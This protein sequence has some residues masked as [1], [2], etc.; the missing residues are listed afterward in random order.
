MEKNVR[1]LGPL[2]I[3]LD[4]L[5]DWCSPD[6]P[7][8]GGFAHLPQLWPQLSNN[9]PWH[10]LPPQGPILPPSCP[11]PQT[12]ALPHRPRWPWTCWWGCTVAG[13]R[14]PVH[15]DSYLYFLLLSGYLSL[16]H[17]FHPVDCEAAG[18]LGS[19]PAKG[20]V[21]GRNEVATVLGRGSLVHRGL[22]SL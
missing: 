15:A 1:V 4:L 18:I 21:R 17:F 14:L 6:S 8:T 16:D 12:P 9:F 19:T 3:H 2:R 7:L 20:Q 13:V 10:Q 11:Y 5:P 22:E